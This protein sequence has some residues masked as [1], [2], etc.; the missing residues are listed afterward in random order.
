MATFSK[1]LSSSG[2]VTHQA[3]CRRKGFPT[4]SRTFQTL[5]DAKKWARSVERSWDTGEAP[6]TAAPQRTETTLADVLRRYRDEVAPT[7][8]GGAIEQLGINALLRDYRAFAD[9][10]VCDLSPAVMAAWRDERLKLVKSSTVSRQMN[11]LYSAINKARLDWGLPIPECK[12]KRPKS[13]PHRDRV[14]TDEEEAKLLAAASSNEYLCAAIRFALATAMRAGEIIALRWTDVDEK[15]KRCRVR[16][17]KNGTPRDVPLS[18]KALAALEPLDRSTK[19]VFEG[20]TS[21]T[22]KRLFIRLTRSAEVVNFHFHDCRHTALT[23][24]AKSGMNPLQLAVVSG[25]KD[26]KMLARYTHL[27]SDDVVGLMG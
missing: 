23:R 2:E 25:H 10:P 6:A 15:R 26:I 8:R 11:V 12:V 18:S 4:L 19:R 27:K 3:K 5:A 17:A 9:T 22:L 7:H 24:Y 1:R 20:L 14:L 13:P 21:E 16:E